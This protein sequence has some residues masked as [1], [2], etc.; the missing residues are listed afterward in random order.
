MRAK[1][2]DVYYE[3]LGKIEKNEY[4][5]LS[6]IPSENTLIKEYEVS[7][8]T[9]RK[10]L[11]LLEQNGY[12]QKAKGKA[13]IVLNYNRMN[14]PISGLTT[15]TE[16]AESSNWISST[17]VEEFKIVNGDTDIMKKLDIGVDEDAYYLLRVRTINDER[18]IIDKDY[19]N[20]KFVPFLTKE[21]CQGSIYKYFEE[22]L[23]LK[24][25]FA[26]KEIV[27]RP[28][29]KEDKRYMDMEGYEMTVVVKSYVYLEDVS[30]FQYTE[31]RHRPDKFSFVD[32]ARRSPL[33]KDY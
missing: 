30:L 14:F 17:S 4:K 9:V 15:F 28:S 5:A 6:Q 29:T 32:F 31:S 27:V 25:S 26:R 11:A 16:L 19:I 8:D 2:M 10:A 21:I 18:I 12:I 3:I 20:R 33:K 24:I 23:G 7:K 22:T 13:A 1:Y